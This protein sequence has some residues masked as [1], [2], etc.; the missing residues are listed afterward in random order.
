[1]AK[2]AKRRLEEDEE[3]KSFQFPEFDDQKF[4][5][6]EFEQTYA[7]A[8]A[9]G[10]VGLMAVASYLVDRAQVPAI[11]AVFAALAILVAAPFLI[12]RVRPL[13][14]DYTKGDWAGLIVIMLF[15]WLGLWFVLLNVLP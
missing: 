12:Q 15:G 7:T 10:L 6:H 3:Y 13:S 9:F 8:I 1:M 14:S 11:L 4:L 2:K 5:D